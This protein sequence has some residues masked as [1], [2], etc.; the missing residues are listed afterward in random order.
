MVSGGT[1]PDE[2]SWTVV[3]SGNTLASGGPNSIGYFSIN[4]PGC[5][6]VPEGNQLLQLFDSM[7]NGWNSAFY[8]ITNSANAVVASGTL[9]S[10]SYG[11]VM[12]ALP[13]DCYTVN[14]TNGSNPS[15]VSWSI[16]GSSGSLASG[17]TG[18][19]SLYVG[20]PTCAEGVYRV[21]MNDSSGDG[22]EGG[23]WTIT[24]TLNVEYGNGTL[25]DGFTGIETLSL[26]PDCYTMQIYGGSYPLEITWSL[27]EVISGI[28]IISGTGNSGYVSFEIGNAPCQ[29]DFVL[30]EG[31][32]SIEL[33][34][35]NDLYG[36]I[37]IINT[38]GEEVYFTIF[39]TPDYSF[40]IITLPMGCYTFQ[41]STT[42]SSATYIMQGWNGLYKNGSVVSNNY[43][44]FCHEGI[45]R[46][47]MDATACNFNSG[48]TIDDGSCCYGV[49]TH[50]QMQDVGPANFNWS[51]FREGDLVTKHKGAFDGVACFDPSCIYI[52]SMN[53]PTGQAGGGAHLTLS[54]AVTGMVFSEAEMNT[55]L[56]YSERI[57]VGY[58]TGCTDMTATN[59]DPLAVCDNETCCYENPVTFSISLLG[60]GNNGS[61]YIYTLDEVFVDLVNMPNGYFSEKDLCLAAGC[62]KFQFHWPANVYNVTVT[63]GDTELLNLTYVQNQQ[64][65][66]FCVEDLDA[67]CMDDSSCNYD[68]TVV[69]DNAGCCAANCMNFS[70][71][72][73]LHNISS[74]LY[75]E[76]FDST[77]TKIFGAEA[78][79]NLDL[80]L[81][82]GCY[83]LH[84][85]NVVSSNSNFVVTHLNTGEIATSGFMNYQNVNFNFCMYNRLGCM[86]VNACNYDAEATSDDGSCCFNTCAKLYL[87][88]FGNDGWEGAS[89]LLKNVHGSLFSG[90]LAEGDSLVIDLCLD[91]GCYGV[92]VYGAWD[93]ESLW[94]LKQGDN[95]IASGTPAALTSFTIGIPTPGCTDPLA[96][97]FS[98]DANCDDCSCDYTCKADFN[99][100]SVVSVGDF[101]IL[102]AYFDCQE[103]C[104]RWDLT[105]NA[106]IDV[107][108]V[109][110]FT[111][112]FGVCP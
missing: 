50:V 44:A 26:P 81:P 108:D 13:D 90:T 88:D 85:E 56:G 70:F 18:A 51:L 73:Q 7:N 66:E 60:S 6:L 36:Q 31:E 91:S 47:C 102:L 98:N 62:Y 74:D 22:W 9:S 24:G 58:R 46:G 52:I 8:S 68:E 54:D 19:A 92:E 39:N 34:N 94:Q 83:T 65:Y 40:D 80:C 99:N 3:Q 37:S 106:D 71:D 41:F 89:I 95:I 93:G 23:E 17:Y 76:L 48:A 21:V 69:I 79:G 64:W 4:T 11:Q 105:Y 112:A 35:S 20:T 100:D 111:S 45:T 2:V 49:C 109:L 61:V 101:L 82:D 25:Y 96:Y 1:Y 103:N 59:Y 38:Y 63:Q 10:G 77:G 29:N 86:D 28:T 12:L 14:V 15:Q 75:W 84:R 87:I 43:F 72:Y 32:F 5:V 53:D 16:T 78:D 30:N 42:A 27:V 110:L 107:Q 57:G 97:N 55:G 67:G 104:C 33:Y